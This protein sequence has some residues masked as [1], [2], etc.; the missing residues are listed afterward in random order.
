MSNKYYITKLKLW[1]YSITKKV[2]CTPIEN[3][4]HRSMSVS[5]TTVFQSIIVQKVFSLARKMGW[6][7]K[8][9]WRAGLMGVAQIG[10]CPVSG[11][12]HRKGWMT[13]LSQFRGDQPRGYRQIVTPCWLTFTTTETCASPWPI[14]QMIRHPMR[15]CILLCFL[16]GAY[17]YVLPAR[18][19]DSKLVW[20]FMCPFNRVCSVAWHVLSTGTGLSVKTNANQQYQS[21]KHSL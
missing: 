13:P 15:S 3:T 21:K 10:K 9:L 5:I 4:Q 14:H 8:V 17:T 20:A 18:H 16:S 2:L 1:Y 19:S 7:K 12:Q 6:L 11:P